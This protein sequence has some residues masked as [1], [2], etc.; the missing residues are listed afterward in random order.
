MRLAALVTTNRQPLSHCCLS[1]AS[2]PGFWPHWPVIGCVPSHLEPVLNHNIL[3]TTVQFPISGECD[4]DYDV[5]TLEHYGY[6]RTGL[7]PSVML[8]MCGPLKSNPLTAAVTLRGVMSWSCDILAVIPSLITR[9]LT[10]SAY[11]HCQWV[12]LNIH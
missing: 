6:I 7:T 10:C 5:G 12:T 2:T 8:G 3:G 4:A 9:L 1:T 11:C